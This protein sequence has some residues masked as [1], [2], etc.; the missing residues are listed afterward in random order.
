MGT[1][2]HTYLPRVEVA[3]QRVRLDLVKPESLSVR[4]NLVLEERI[5]SVTGAARR[6]IEESRAGR[7]TKAAVQDGGK[8]H[9]FARNALRSV[10]CTG[11][12]GTCCMMPII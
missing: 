8:R 3:R 12:E 11:M 2:S 4:D 7:G 9:S 5:R 6:F 10:F 1:S